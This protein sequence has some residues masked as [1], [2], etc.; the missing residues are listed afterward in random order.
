MT[1][2]SSRRKL[3]EDEISKLDQQASALYE[4]AGKQARRAYRLRDLEKRRTCLDEL[5][6]EM[7]ALGRC[8]QLK[9]TS[10]EPGDSYGFAVLTSKFS[11]AQ[12]SRAE[13]IRALCG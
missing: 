9:D 7:I 3:T 11:T 5:S 13:Y 1:E 2:T 12:S 4:Q 6:T 8:G 10:Y